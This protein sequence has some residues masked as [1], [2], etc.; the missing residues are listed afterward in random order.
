MKTKH[1]PIVKVQLSLWPKG[2]IMVYNEDQT[3]FYGGIAS[4]ELIKILKKDNHKA[5]Y[6][7]HINKQRK[8]VL[9]KK[10]PWQEW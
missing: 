6:Y 4:K 10:A 3:I 7:Y 1:K 2:L 5:F 9:D 8:I